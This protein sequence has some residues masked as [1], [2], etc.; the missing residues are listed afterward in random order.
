MI[1]NDKQRLFGNIAKKAKKNDF[2]KHKFGENP[3]LDFAIFV[4]KAIKGNLAK[5][6]LEAIVAMEQARESMYISQKYAKSDKSV[7]ALEK[8]FAEEHSKTLS[9]IV[10]KVKEM[11]KMLENENNGKQEKYNSTPENDRIYD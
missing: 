4:N 5:S 8:I 7:D 3:D 9:R 10:A 6:C 2:D 11:N 1:E